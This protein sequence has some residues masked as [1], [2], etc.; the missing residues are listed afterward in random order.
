MTT[1]Y[2]VTSRDKFPTGPHWVILRFSSVHIPGDERSRTH[3]GHG[4]P[5][6]SV[7]KADYQVF[8]DEGAW[9]AEI[10]KLAESKFA[11]PDFVAFKASGPA[12]LSINV[13]V[14]ISWKE[15]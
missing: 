9:K 11:H 2:Y 7:S 6:H 4:Y 3:P 14:D 1:G 13:D 10:K 12:K 5:A 8:L 15:D